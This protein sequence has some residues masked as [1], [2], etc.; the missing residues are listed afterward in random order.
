MNQLK[1]KEDGKT[2]PSGK[3]VTPKKPKPTSEESVKIPVSCALTEKRIRD[4]AREEIIK[5][6]K[7]IFIPF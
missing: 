2:N 6:H 1:K 3:P 7:D 4:I 5:W